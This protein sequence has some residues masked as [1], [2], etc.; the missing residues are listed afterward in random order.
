MSETVPE[1]LELPEPERREDVRP[2]GW[3]FFLPALFGAVLVPKRLGARLA[4]STWT[5][6]L[7]AHFVSLFV[8]LVLVGLANIALETSPWATVAPWFPGPELTPQTVVHGL[9]LGEWLRLP[10][11]LV[12]TTLYEATAGNG[13]IYAVFGGVALVQAVCWLAALLIMP[14]IAAGERTR[15]LYV[16]SVK[17]VL[18][19]T[20]CLA[21]LALAFV[22]MVYVGEYRDGAI[23]PF[24]DIGYEEAMTGTG[25][26][27][28]VWWLS[29]A[30]RL[31]AHYGGPAEGPA[32]Q[33]ARPRCNKCG[34]T[35][36]G[37]P[38]AGQCPECGRDVRR[39]MPEYRTD[40]P[41]A[42]AR[43][44]WS[45]IK[46]FCLTTRNICLQRDFYETLQVGPTVRSASSFALWS[47]SLAGLIVGLTYGGTNIDHLLCAV[48]LEGILQA[49][50]PVVTA[51]VVSAL[52]CLVAVGVATLWSA[53]LGRRDIRPRCI[54]VCYSSAM[55]APV[56]LVSIICSWCLY[57][58]DAHGWL[59]G[60]E[61]L[62]EWEFV[63]FDGAVLI[64]LPFVS[65]QLGVLVWACVRLVR[66]LR[67]V[68][69]AS[70]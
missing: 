16:R 40:P 62:F 67:D 43:G 18:W 31:G 69:F 14:F 41:W 11:A 51:V 3:L 32:W 30:L 68:R 38:L 66:A 28:L 55:L 49:L 44:L 60:W 21:P 56:L 48:E 9:S 50:I 53:R 63:R 52:V 61:P 47:C 45:S 35:I 25:A 23:D 59:R 42:K 46:A 54:A 13:D 4:R 7:A 15:L 37:L 20:A 39:S 33:P 10:F 29:V 22:A 58:I 57:I 19:S 12:V 2:V 65:V 17:L 1:Y 34:Y 64:L 36:V 24:P 26:L 27:W 6:A 8:V 5:K 70:G